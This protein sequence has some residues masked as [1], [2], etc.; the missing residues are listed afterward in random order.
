MK[1]L[2]LITAR[3]GSKGVPGK[4][5]KELGGIPLVGFKAISALQS[6]YCARLIISTDSPDIQKVARQYGAEVPFTRPAEL[7]SDTA[8]SLDV[9][10]HAMD[11]VENQEGQTYDALML[12]EPSSPFATHADYDAAVEIMVNNRANVV[13][14][15]GPAGLHSSKHG[16]LDESGRIDRHVDRI[17]RYAVRQQDQREYTLNGALYLIQWDYF[18]HEQRI[19]GDQKTTFAH[20]M[21]RAYSVEIDE[22]L[23]LEWAEF[24]VANGHV[25]MG[26]WRVDKPVVQGQSGDGR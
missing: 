17:G 11:Y 23:D 10:A 9:V 20:I 25:D 6:K 3:G 5:L 12:L 21:G 1:V 4:N 14:G 7:A 8:S 2:F 18:K 13:V 19:M 16:K 24:L 22:P 26:Q 15:V